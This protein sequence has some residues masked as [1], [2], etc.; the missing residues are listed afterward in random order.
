MS[1]TM[2]K[3]QQSKSFE[4]GHTTY[5]CWKSLFEEIAIKMNRNTEEHRRGEEKILG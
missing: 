5:G 1:D 4:E 2:E 3:K